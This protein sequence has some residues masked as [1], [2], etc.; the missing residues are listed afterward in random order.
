MNE[1][2]GKNVLVTG[3]VGGLGRE[4]SQAFSNA[5][6]RVAVHHFGQANEAKQFLD[7]LTPGS[8]EF[9]ADLSKWEA[10]GELIA[11]VE[12]DLGPIDILINNAGVMHELPTAETNAAVW[13][14]TIA[15][16]LSAVMSLSQAVLPGMH[17]RGYGRIISVSSQLAF[18]GAPNLSAYCAAKAG[19]LGLTR[20]LAREHGPTVRINAVAP[21]PTETPMIAPF[22]DDEWRQAR[23]RNLVRGALATPGQ[24][25]QSVVFLASD[26][27]ELFHGQTLHCNGGG[28]LA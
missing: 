22:A 7:S 8:M 6:A 10:A 21:G 5:G 1:F 11:T 19:V 20:A 9:D 25:A 13:N 14:Q 23:T 15:L 27:A 28:Y 16:D 17:K 3:A 18:I 4:I 26:A 24:V 2:E 12:N